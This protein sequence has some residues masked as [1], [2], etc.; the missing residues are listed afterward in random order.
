LKTEKSKIRGKGQYHGA[1]PTQEEKWSRG[2]MSCPQMHPFPLV[3]YMLI[4][5]VMAL[6]C[7]VLTFTVTNTFR[8]FYIMW[9][10]L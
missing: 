1:C 9:L 4:L 7:T 8:S 3:Y 10:F 6:R 5:G 2:S